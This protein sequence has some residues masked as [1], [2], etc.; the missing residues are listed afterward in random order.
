MEELKKCPFCGGEAE[1]VSE[2]NHASFVRCKR[3]CCR[4]YVFISPKVAIEAWNERVK[5]MKVIIYTVDDEEPDCNRCDHCCGEDY[6]C[7]KQC[8]AQHGWN[9]YERIEMMLEVG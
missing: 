5:Q 7:L 6:Y 4:T 8:G 1:I 9:G 3:R 2:S